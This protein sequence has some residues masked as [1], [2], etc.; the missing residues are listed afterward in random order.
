MAAMKKMTK[1]TKSWRAKFTSR[2]FAW[3]VLGPIILSVSCSHKGYDQAL[4]SGLET[5]P[6]A[7]EF[8]Q[9]FP[10]SDNFI[11]YYTGQAGEPIWNSK[12][13]LYGRYILSLQVKI[14]FDE[15]RTKIIGLDD[16]Q[17][18]LSEKYPKH[19]MTALSSCTVLPTSDL[20]EKNGKE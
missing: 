7:S 20:E 1:A 14:T 18:Y 9:F 5:I 3:L 12:A 4:E 17:F 6:Y 19:L 13:G 16:P 15:T 2:R 11:S 8:N 10:G